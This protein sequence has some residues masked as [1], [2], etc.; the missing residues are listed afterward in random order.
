LCD[1][2]HVW[3]GSYDYE[4]IDVELLLSFVRTFYMCLEE[5]VKK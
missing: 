5:R 2:K 3:L 4:T 1:I